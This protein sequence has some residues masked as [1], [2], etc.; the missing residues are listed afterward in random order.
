MM[1]AGFSRAVRLCGTD[2]VDPV[3]RVLR[4]GPLSAELQNGALRYV[5][6]GETEMI[7][8]IAFLLRDENWGTFAPTIEDLKVDEQPH[9]FSVTYR[10]TCADAKRRLVYD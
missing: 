9:A 6:L 4:A 8:A 3:S 1:S 10:A 7:R 2:A 5:R